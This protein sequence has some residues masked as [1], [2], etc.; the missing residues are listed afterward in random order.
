MQWPV[1]L[2]PAGEVGRAYGAKTTP[3]MFVIDPE[4]VLAYDGALDNAPMGKPKGGKNVPFLENALEDV[5]KG[6]KPGTPRTPPYGC[7][8]KY[9]K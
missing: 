6:E 3:H 1:L 5:L 2:D 9:G 4:G 7:S 8:V